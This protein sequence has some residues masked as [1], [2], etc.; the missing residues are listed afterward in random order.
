MKLSRSTSTNRFLRLGIV[1]LALLSTFSKHRHLV[2]GRCE[3]RVAETTSATL[4]HNEA[5]TDLQQVTYQDIGSIISDLPH[6]SPYRHFD[7]HIFAVLA[8][9][10]CCSASSSAIS[11]DDHSSLAMVGTRAAVMLGLYALGVV[12]GQTL[13]ITDEW[14]VASGDKK[15]AD[16]RLLLASTACR[17]SA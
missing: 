4:R 9:F 11:L 17:R 15:S 7:D 10:P 5:V 12:A 3:V 2:R 13:R 6:L 14:S 1:M 8:R 16:A